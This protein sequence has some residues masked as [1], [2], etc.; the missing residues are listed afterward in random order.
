M[1]AINNLKMDVA[2]T[3]TKTKAPA[4]LVA[5]AYKALEEKVA[6]AKI[7]A[8]RSPEERMKGLVTEALPTPASSD[9]VA[10]ALQLRSKLKQFGLE[11]TVQLMSVNE[12]GEARRLIRTALAY[13]VSGGTLS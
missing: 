9:D 2:L 4:E 10:L 13:Y 1:D 11:R 3:V 12:R 8:V 7:D 5:D 6:Q